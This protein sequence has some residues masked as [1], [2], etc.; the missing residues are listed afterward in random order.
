MNINKT[1]SIDEIKK[2]FSNKNEKTEY[3]TKLYK[4]TNITKDIPKTIKAID[5]EIINTWNYEISN[6]IIRKLFQNTDK[7]KVGEFS[8]HAIK[9]MINEWEKLKLGEIKWPFSAK[10][11][12]QYIQSVNKRD[13]PEKEKDTIVQKDAIRF[14]RIKKINTARNDFIEYLIVKHNDNVTPTLRHSR[15]V[16]FYID[17]IPFDQKVSKSVTTEFQ[18]DYG[19]NWKNYA[20]AHPEEVGK[21]LYKYQDENR[22][23]AEARLLI[24]YLE[25]NINEEDIYKCINKANLKEPY[26]IKFDYIHSHNI[27]KTYETN[28]YIILLHK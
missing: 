3:L 22:F 24:V 14:R 20:I 5:E 2:I 19:E 27:R 12:D 6:K 21:Y 7:Y 1:I 4:E 8:S 26:H 9:E 17:G 15:G 23:G 11:F 16:D 25:D 10:G 13:I 28:C 18:N